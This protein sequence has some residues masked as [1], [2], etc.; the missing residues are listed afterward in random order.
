[1][2]DNSIQY[3]EKAET[4]LQK[5]FIKAQ[6]HCLLCGT[7]LELQ[8]IRKDEI[9]EIQEEARCCECD[10]KTRVKNYTLH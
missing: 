8:H 10:I 2:E 7:T 3:F 4:V 9:Q 5:E 1:M 6:N